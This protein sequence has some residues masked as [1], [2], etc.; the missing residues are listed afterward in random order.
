MIIK[1]EI[2]DVGAVRGTYHTQLYTHISRLSIK[3]LHLLELILHNFR[4][5][6]VEEDPERY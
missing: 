5:V 3:E 4:Q 1:E 2:L 6:E